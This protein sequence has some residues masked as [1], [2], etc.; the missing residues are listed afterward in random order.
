MKL[1]DFGCHILPWRWDLGWENPSWTP[2]RIAEATLT[3]RGVGALVHGNNAH[4][5]HLAGCGV[6]AVDQWI[7]GGNA[8]ITARGRKTT[9]FFDVKKTTF[10]ETSRHI[11]TP[12]FFFDICETKLVV[13]KAGPTSTSSQKFGW[14]YAGAVWWWW[15]PWSLA[16]QWA[17]PNLVMTNITNWFKSPFSNGKLT[18]SMTMYIELLCQILAKYPLGI[19]I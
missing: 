15:S 2:W 5:F 18:S 9:D 17:S 1:F 12:Y 3:P 8:A 6:P 10:S 16:S 19:N 4:R 7:T 11:E 14:S 13:V